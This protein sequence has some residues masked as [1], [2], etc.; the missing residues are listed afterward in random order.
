MNAIIQDARSHATKQVIVGGA[1]DLAESSQIN[2]QLHW[3]FLASVIPFEPMTDSRSHEPSSEIG[4][5]QGQLACKI[6][7]ARIVICAMS[8]A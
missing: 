6:A 8:C 5:T 3:R 4:N 2:A 1:L 7:K